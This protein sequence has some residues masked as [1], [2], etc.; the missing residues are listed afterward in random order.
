[1]SS[2][3]AQNRKHVEGPWASSSL[4]VDFVLHSCESINCSGS[5][6]CRSWYSLTV[7]IMWLTLV[8]LGDH[9]WER[10]CSGCLKCHSLSPLVVI[11]TNLWLRATCKRK[12]RQIPKSSSCLLVLSLITHGSTLFFE[13]RGFMLISLS[14]SYS[15]K[16]YYAEEFWEVNLCPKK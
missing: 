1:M 6:S 8:S 3:E 2:T 13:V 14:L 5:K 16:A 4:I 7:A 15:K 11:A 12:E 9:A 10:S